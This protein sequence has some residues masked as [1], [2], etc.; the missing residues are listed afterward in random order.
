MGGCWGQLPV[1]MDE[2]FMEQ[3]IRGTQKPITGLVFTNYPNKKRL[4]L[5]YFRHQMQMY[6]GEAL[7]LV[8]FSKA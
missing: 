7:C 8:V 4:P 3:K 1:I 2:K 5:S 6:I